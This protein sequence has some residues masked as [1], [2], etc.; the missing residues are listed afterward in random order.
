MPE[1]Q[2]DIAALYHHHSSY[3]EW[4]RIVQAD[5]DTLPAHSTTYPGSVRIDLPGRGDSLEMGLGEALAKRRTI[6]RF[7]GES[8]ALHSVGVLLHA[9]FGI[10]PRLPP[11]ADEVEERRPPPSAGALYPLELHVLSRNT[12]DLPDGRYHYDPRSHQLEV[13]DE[14]SWYDD[15]TPALI[16]PYAFALVNMVI[17]VVGIPGRTMVKYGQRGYRFMLLDAGHLA[18]N[19]C[20]VAPALDLGALPV[21]GFYDSRLHQALRLATGEVPLYLIGIGRPLSR[22]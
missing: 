11:A 2:P 17:A 6:R 3:S 10:S 22:E 21:G 20:L 7:S 13:L 5:P 8:L 18:Q 12:E 9:S 4:S 16:D 1:Y 19:I 15:L 14:G